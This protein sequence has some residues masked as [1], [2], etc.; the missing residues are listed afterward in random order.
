MILMPQKIFGFLFIFILTS[1]VIDAEALNKAKPGAPPK[2]DDSREARL[3]VWD[4]AAEK[5]AP[6][7]TLGNLSP[8]NY[9]AAASAKNTYTLDIPLDGWTSNVALEFA[10]AR[11]SRN[12]SGHLETKP[13]LSEPDRCYG[14][15]SSPNFT[16]V[17]PK[18]INDANSATAYVEYSYTAVSSG[19]RIPTIRARFNRTDFRDAAI[20][21]FDGKNIDPGGGTGVITCKFDTNRL[22]SDQSYFLSVDFISFD[23]PVDPNYTFTITKANV[24][25]EDYPAPPEF[26]IDG[27]WIET[28]EDAKAWING[29]KIELLSWCYDAGY[30]DQIAVMIKIVNEYG[31]QYDVYVWANDILTLLN[32]TDTYQVAVAGRWA[33]YLEQDGDVKVWN[34][35][36]DELLHIKN[37][38]YRIA[39]G[40]DDSLLIWDW[41][42]DLYLWLP[43]EGLYKVDEDDIWFL[44]DTSSA[45]IY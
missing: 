3:K 22:L 25:T 7:E 4:E 10:P 2:R 31:N 11:F 19:I 38:G 33:C 24:V 5:N 44:C 16:I 17:K 13:N 21:L 26:I 45:P 15:W 30:N 29:Y 39:S 36:T 35:F 28:D 27:V 20:Y 9:R 12:T 34:P 8:K 41:D 6:P 42:D 14:F 32:T 40:G 43:G 1:G 18:E 37:D 23:G